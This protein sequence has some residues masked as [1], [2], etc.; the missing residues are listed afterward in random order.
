MTTISAALPQKTVSSPLVD[1]AARQSAQVPLP[2]LGTAPDL[3]V[4]AANTALKEIAARLVS[5]QSGLAQLYADLDVAVTRADLPQAVRAAAKAV[6]SLRV[7]GSNAEALKA[8]VLNSGLFT[9]A[10]PASG[11][12]MSGD[13]KTALLSLRRT[14]LARSI[15]ARDASRSAI[16]AALSWRST[17]RTTARHAIDC[18]AR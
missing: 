7:T 3:A 11:A 5:Q 12:A 6:L 18:D 4:P 14:K 15:R 2:G 1:P 9:E 16:A 8:A 10:M 13:M 17:G